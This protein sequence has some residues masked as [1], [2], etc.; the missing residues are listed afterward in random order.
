MAIDEN[1]CKQWVFFWD[2]LKISLIES[3]K[4]YVDK[5]TIESDG[6][7]INSHGTRSAVFKRAPAKGCQKV[8]D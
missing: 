1:V 8:I 6:S 3:I 7:N 4:Q 2:E 5:F